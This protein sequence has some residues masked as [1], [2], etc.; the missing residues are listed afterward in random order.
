MRKEVY[1]PEVTKVIGWIAGSCALRRDVLKLRA[2]MYRS[3]RPSR[4]YCT[5]NIGGVL[6]FDRML[7]TPAAWPDEGINTRFRIGMDARFDVHRKEL[8]IRISPPTQVDL[9]YEGLVQRQRALVAEE[10]ER[11]NREQETP[12]ES[13]HQYPEDRDAAAGVSARKRLIPPYMR[14]DE[15]ADDGRSRLS[16]RPKYQ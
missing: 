9:I 12:A 11:A 10:T 4:C 6:L 2:E 8:V 7:L 13:G 16:K 5:I 14:A 15:L 3:R 1:M